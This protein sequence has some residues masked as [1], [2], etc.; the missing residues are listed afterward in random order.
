MVVSPVVLFVYNRIIHT[1]RTISSLL[2][3]SL[4]SSTDLIIYSD[5]PRNESDLNQ[6]ENVRQ[7]LTEINGFKSLTINLSE[8]NLGLSGSIIHGV[9]ESL[10]KYDKIIVLE[11]DLVVS[12]FFLMYMNDALNRY[13]DDDRVAS[14]HG[15]TYPTDCALPETFFMPG[16]DCWGWATWRRA[17]SFFNPDAEQLYKKLKESDKIKKFCFNGHSNH[18]KLLQQQVKGKVDSWAIRWHAS[19]YLAGKLT[20][21]PGHSLVQNIGNDGSGTHCGNYN[22]HLIKL[23][24]QQVVVNEIE[25]EVSKVGYDAFEGFFKKS[26]ESI[27]RK[28]MR[29]VF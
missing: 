15:Y 4:A 13:Q 6:V 21:Y 9:S 18:S 1:Q 25:V 14:I 20:L 8:K 22:S 17:W 26:G 23:Y 29:K 2:G 24:E 3:N 27:F 19:A 5:G 12:S 11:D 10:K 7:F 16:A 28:M